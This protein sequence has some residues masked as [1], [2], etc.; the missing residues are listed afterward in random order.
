MNTDEI[1]IPLKPQWWWPLVAGVLVGRVLG[2]VFSGRPG[3]L[4]ETMSGSFA[5]LAPIA[6]SAVTV[7]VA[8]LRARRTWSYY[9]WM[10][11]LANV[12]FAVGAFLTYLEGLICVILAAPLFAIVGG[13]AGL[14]V[15]AA[16]RGTRWMRRA[17]YCC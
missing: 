13:V 14:I 10:G 16:F 5:L 2:A 9:F 11:A 3:N 1:R 15:G 6:V 17:V 4:F 12:L 8:E 7:Y